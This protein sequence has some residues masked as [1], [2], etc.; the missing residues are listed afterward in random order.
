MAKDMSAADDVLAHSEDEGEWDDEPDE[1]ENRPSG[2]QVISA[3][4]PTVLAEELLAEAASRGVRP[5]ELVRQAVEALLRDQPRPLAGLIVHGA[6]KVRIFS[7]LDAELSETENLNEVVETPTEPEL[8]T[9][10][11]AA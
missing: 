11:G 7:V 5:S 8:I 9:V 3:R 6:G 10:V 2:S 4:L 1:I